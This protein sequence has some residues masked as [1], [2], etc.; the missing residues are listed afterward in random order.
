MAVLD[1]IVNSHLL[2]KYAIFFQIYSEWKPK[3]GPGVTEELGNIGHDPKV[4]FVDDFV[5][6]LVCLTGTADRKAGVLQNVDRGLVVDDVQALG[7]QQPNQCEGQ[8]KRQY[9]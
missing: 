7:D 4:I 3:C 2:V 6:G 1:I 9:E 8:W 5:I